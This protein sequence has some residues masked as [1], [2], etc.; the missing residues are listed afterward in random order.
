MVKSL[1]MPGTMKLSHT[2]SP[3]EHQKMEALLGSISNN[4]FK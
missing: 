1:L 3:Q 4:L 2:T